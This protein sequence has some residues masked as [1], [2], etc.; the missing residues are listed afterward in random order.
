[1][2][3][4]YGPFIWEHS[5]NVQVRHGDPVRTLDFPLA[6]QH[7]GMTDHE[8]AATLG[9]TRDQV[10]QIRVMLEARS[11]NRRRYFRQY[12]LGGNRRFRGVSEA[13]DTRDPYRAEAMALRNMIRHDPAQVRKY[14]EAGWWADDTLTRW[15]SRHTAHH[16]DRKAVMA[17]P[18][19]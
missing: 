18:A 7:R 11:Y 14:I 4:S 9:L 15:L 13:Q 12:E 19:G 1:M 6:R 3:A 2:V 8:M 16:G 5:N 17:P 10:L